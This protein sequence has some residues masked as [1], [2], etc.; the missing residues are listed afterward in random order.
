[1]TPTRSQPLRRITP[2]LFLV[3][4]AVAENRGGWQAPD[5]ER[6]LNRRG[7]EQSRVIASRLAHFDGRRP[8]RVLSSPA[9]RCRQTVEPL[10]AACGLEV[11]QADWLNEGSQPELAFE[12]LRKLA[13]RLDPPSGL[14]GPVVACSH[15]DVIWGVLEH[16]HQLGVDLGPQPEAPKGGVWIIAASP[17]SVRAATFYLPDETRK[18]NA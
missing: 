7:F 14:G 17:A 10:A 1:M 3:R 16:L 4:H 5:E 15:R 11:V 12:K 8:S 18:A 6:P 2:T 9:V 13:A